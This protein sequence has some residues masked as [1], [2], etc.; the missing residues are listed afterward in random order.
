MRRTVRLTESDLYRIVKRVINESGFPQ[1]QQTVL[2]WEKIYDNLFDEVLEIIEYSQNTEEF[3]NNIDEF[4]NNNESDLNKIPNE[5][6]EGI[7]RFISSII[8]RHD[9]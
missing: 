3:E 6:R 4:M 1:H 5:K 7:M 9:F 2:S 8:E